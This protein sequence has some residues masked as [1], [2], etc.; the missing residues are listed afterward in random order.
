M[1]VY[2][3]MRRWT[4]LS[5]FDQPSLVQHLIHAVINRALSVLPFDFAHLFLLSEALVSPKLSDDVEG[6]GVW[7]SKDEGVLPN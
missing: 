2:F 7:S 3:R 5:A 1:N 4:V 6:R